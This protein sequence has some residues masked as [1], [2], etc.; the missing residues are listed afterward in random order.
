VYSGLDEE[1]LARLCSERDRRAESELYVRYAARLFSLCRRYCNNPDEA[2]DLM[3]ETFIKA[4][5]K[6]STYKYRGKGSLY[7]WISRIAVNMA[8]NGIR[9]SKL[10]FVSLDSFRSDNEPDPS[11]EEV[12]RISEEK[13]TEMISGLPETQRIIF[14]MYCIEEYSHKEIAGMLGISER[15]STSLLVKARSS[16][17]KR[18]GEYLKQ[19]ERI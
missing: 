1:E 13:L 18:I 16:L 5:E 7:S 9:R 15:G 4:L 17:K 2:S 3:Q 19:S 11:G 6:I 10:V 12:S 8:L 14:N